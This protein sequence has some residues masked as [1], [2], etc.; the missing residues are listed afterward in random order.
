MHMH[1]P[2][3]AHVVKH[4]GTYMMLPESWDQTF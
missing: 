4:N 1:F 3:F 2:G